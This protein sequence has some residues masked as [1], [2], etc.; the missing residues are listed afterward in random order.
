[1]DI[2]N[3]LSW[4][5]DIIAFYL[6]FVVLVLFIKSYLVRERTGRDPVCLGRRKKTAVRLAETAV[7]LVFILLLLAMSAL[8]FYPEA[9][10]ATG[11]LHPL[12]SNWAA[13]SALAV[14]ALSGWLYIRAAV[15]SGDL[16]QLGVDPETPHPPYGGIYSRIRQ[17]VALAVFL[18][19]L[20]MLLFIPTTAT[21]GVL[22]LSAAALEAGAAA[23]EKWWEVRLGRPYRE[24]LA[25]TNRY[26]PFKPRKRNRPTPPAS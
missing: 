4:K 5:Q 21:A 11:R 24:Y 9:L 18:S 16:W 2:M 23:G 3:H 14:L 22:A 6:P 17:P 8:V 15:D 20:G 12:E 26:L 1:M 7:T 13:V 19:G 10:L 25:A